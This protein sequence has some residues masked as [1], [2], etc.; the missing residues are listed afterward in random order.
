[1]HSFLDVSIIYEFEFLGWVLFLLSLWVISLCYMASI[2]IRYNKSYLFN[3]NFIGLGLFLYV[4][5]F[6]S[7]FFI[8]YLGFEICLLPVLFLILVYGYQPERVQAGTYIFFYTLLGSLP[9]FFFVLN[10]SIELGRD[11]ICVVLLSSYKIS[12]IYIFFMLRA[13]LIKF[14]IYGVHL[15]L[16]KAHVEAPVRGS[17]ILAGVILKLGGYGI[18]RF[19]VFS[20]EFNCVLSEVIISLSIWGALF[21]SLS[22]LRHLNIKLLVARSSVVHIGVCL[23]GLFVINNWG[24]IGC[25]YIIVAHG[26]CSRGLFF[27]VNVIYERRG[28]QSLLVSKGLINLLPILSMWWFLILIYNI[29]APPSL[30]LI[31]EI[32]LILGLI[33]WKISLFFIIFFMTFFRARYNLFLYSLSQ[34]GKFVF[35]LRFKG[36]NLIDILVGFLHWVPLNLLV[37]RG[38]YVY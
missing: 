19:M 10:L 33:R 9:L 7:S 34:H 18:L 29:R 17:I 1:M 3:L 30:N 13:F 22:C 4:T 12:L 26:L 8:F 28:R 15:W 16:L 37:L 25:I 31:R 36:L 32:I 11:F 38:Y 35:N 23:V 24:Y 2:K 20:E 27:F 5:F 21:V 14:P 6:T